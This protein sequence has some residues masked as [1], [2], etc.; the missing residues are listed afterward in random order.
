MRICVVGAGA[1]GG[2]VAAG[3][4]LAGN[5]VMALTSRGP[6]DAI[7]L[8]AGGETRVA[9]FTPIAMPPDL[10][11]VAVKAPALPG[12]APA[13]REMIGPETVVLPLLNGV[14]W[15]F[16]EGEPLRDGVHTTAKL[17]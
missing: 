17:A 5:E 4:A 12:I 8:G 11:V 10:L 13:L 3:L 6:I 7:A 2:W 16:L 1:I 14:P 9:A 15:W